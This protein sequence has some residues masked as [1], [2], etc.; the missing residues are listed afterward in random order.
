[1]KNYTL[2]SP[3]SPSTPPTSPIPLALQ[4][5]TCVTLLWRVGFWVHCAEASFWYL[6]YISLPLCYISISLPPKICTSF[7]TGDV[8]IEYRSIILFGIVL[9]WSIRL[10]YNLCYQVNYYFHDEDY[11][12]DNLQRAIRSIPFALQICDFVF[13][14]FT[15]N[16]VLL[17]ITLP[18][19]YI[20]SYRTQVP[21]GNIDYAAFAG[22]LLAILGEA[23][24]HHQRYDYTW[25]GE[26]ARKKLKYILFRYA[27]PNF[28]LEHLMWVCVFAASVTVSATKENTYLNW[29]GI[30][31][32]M[33]ALLFHISTNTFSNTLRKMGCPAL[34]HYP[35]HCA[36]RLNP[37]RPCY[38]YPC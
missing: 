36:G 9:I 26:P 25:G 34:L 37:W 7:F 6:C 32:F 15:H 1:M 4:W 18:V 10:A 14:A 22:S 5:H 13:I 28:I 31:I 8:N 12:R 27:D 19:Y 16:L 30:G 17:S 23:V 33:L 24:T 29:S 2:A 38:I 35:L 11:R 20:N 3:S 21:L